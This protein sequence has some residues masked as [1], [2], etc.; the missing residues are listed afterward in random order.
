MRR[1]SVPSLWWER[2][3]ATRPSNGLVSEGHSDFAPGGWG[4]S[5]NGQ[6]RQIS[7]V[8]SPEKTAW[9]PLRP[10]NCQ[11]KNAKR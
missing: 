10:E 8:M 9:E 1:K 4:I 7:T 2:F 3:W 6:N 11:G 5:Q